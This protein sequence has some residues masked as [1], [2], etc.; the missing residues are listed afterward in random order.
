MA[1]ALMADA[2]LVVHLA[3]VVFVVAG[4]L[5]VGRF[6]RLLL[7]HLAAAAW[8]VFIAASGGVCPLTPL[9]NELLRRAGREGY[10]SG[11]LEHYV[12]PVIYPEG[13]T[14]EAQWTLAGIVVVVNVC[15][16][17]FYVRGRRR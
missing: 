7:P 8:G 15:V 3:F 16:Y 2:V 13:L 12:A 9:E 14:R 11:F 1:Y 5:L 6:K 4:G 17:G 10:E